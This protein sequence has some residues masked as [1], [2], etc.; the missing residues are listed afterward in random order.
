MALVITV[1]RDGCTVPIAVVWGEGLD[2]ATDKARSWIGKHCTNEEQVT[3]HQ[4]EI[5]ANDV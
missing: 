3:L 1:A 2:D 4:V 5:V